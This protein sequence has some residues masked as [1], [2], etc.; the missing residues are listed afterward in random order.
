MDNKVASTVNMMQATLKARALTSKSYQFDVSSLRLTAL[1]V[2]IR[3]LKILVMALHPNMAK[4]DTSNSTRATAKRV[5]IPMLPTTLT[6]HR[7][8]KV[9]VV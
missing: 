8:K 6:R 2:G 5:V 3:H 4:R 1:L 9:N 7:G